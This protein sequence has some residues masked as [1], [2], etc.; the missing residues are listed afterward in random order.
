M[1]DY[2]PPSVGSQTAQELQ[3]YTNYLPGLLQA[4]ANQAAPIGQSLQAETA[5]IAPQQQ[6]EQSQLFQQYAPQLYA[7]GNQIQSGSTQAGVNTALQELQGQGGQLLNA[8]QQAQEQLDPG[9]YSTRAAEAPQMQN[10]VNAI[11]V[12][13]NGLTASEQ[14]Q[15]E[16]SNAQQDAARGIANTPSQTATVSNAMNYGTALTNK[17]GALSSA[18]NTATNFLNPSQGPVSAFNV[19]TGASSAQN[20]A[21]NP[22]GSQFLGIGSANQGSQMASSLGNSLLGQIGQTNQNNQQILA[23]QRTPFDYVNQGLSAIGSII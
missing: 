23:N 9:Y 11:N 5:Q 21:T 3:A 10:L 8:T 16:Q 17:V 22:G 7:L 15:V 12:T 19:G 1:G 4:T 2:N 18:L 13:G 14:R 20:T 6:A